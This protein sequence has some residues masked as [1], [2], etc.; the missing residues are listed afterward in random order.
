MDEVAQVFKSSSCSDEDIVCLQGLE[1]TVNHVS[2]ALDS[3]SWVHF[4]GHGYQ[5]TTWGMKSALAL[6]DGHLN[7]SQI[8]LKRQ[9]TGKFPFLS[10]YH[11]ASG[12]K[13]L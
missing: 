12:L 4:A 11:V 1:A 6:H 5:D 13:G 8:A 10:T 9:S 2:S 3:C 7:L